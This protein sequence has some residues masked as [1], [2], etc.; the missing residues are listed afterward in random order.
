MYRECDHTAP[1]D[2]ERVVFASVEFPAD[3]PPEEIVIAGVRFVR[4]NEPER[5]E[6]AE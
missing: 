2:G 6:R 3:E 4:A 1:V 5:D